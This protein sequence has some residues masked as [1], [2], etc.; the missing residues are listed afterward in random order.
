[1]IFF[2]GVTTRVT[3]TSSSG[4]NGSLPLIERVAM[5]LPAGISEDI[6]VK[7]TTLVLPAATTPLCTDEVNHLGEVETRMV[8][9]ETTCL[10]LYATKSP[11]SAVLFCI[12]V[13][14]RS[15]RP[16]IFS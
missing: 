11:V 4:F 14:A 16:F 13:V 3:G 5:Y 12:P 9:S 1:M 8:E 6:T 2:V 10:L 15:T 7:G